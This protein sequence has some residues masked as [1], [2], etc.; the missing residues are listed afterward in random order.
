MKI[1]ISIKILAKLNNINNYRDTWKWKAD[2]P[3]YADNIN[4]L[5]ET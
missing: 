4:I 1:V 3:G 2:E 5:A